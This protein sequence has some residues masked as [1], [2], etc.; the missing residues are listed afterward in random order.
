[1]TLPE[2]SN[3][4]D[5]LF[6]N[7]TSGQSPGLDEYEKSVF[8]TKAQNEIVKNYFNPKGN[9]YQEGFDGSQKRQVDF[10]NLMSTYS[11]TSQSEPDFTNPD[12][13]VEI[14]IPND[15]KVFVVINETVEVSYKI[16]STTKN[17]ILQ[18]VPIKYDE[19]LRLN[20]K[21]YKQ[22]L[23]NQAW[24]ILVDNDTIGKKAA[25]VIGHN[26]TFEKYKLR[27]LR[28]PAPIILEDL[29]DDI[30]I[31]GIHNSSECELDEEIHPEI[32]QRA[33]ELAKAAYQGDLNSNVELGKRSE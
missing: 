25:L 21:P 20:S 12:N 5:V 23:K 13:S 7:I 28:R 32:L 30:S 6:N 26:N 2:F 18:V 24:R 19:Y 8:L 17:K 22:P 11:V 27:Y 33:V 9:K 1:M 14:T 15:I 3:E 4:F 16:D 10:S 31:Q 29:G